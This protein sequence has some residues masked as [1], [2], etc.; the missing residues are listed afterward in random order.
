MNIY[1]L[2]DGERLVTDGTLKEIAGYTGLKPGTVK[3]YGTPSGRNKGNMILIKI[4]EDD[5][6]FIGSN[7]PRAQRSFAGKA[8]IPSNDSYEPVERKTY[9]IK[10]AGPV[11]YLPEPYTKMLY[12]NMFKNWR[13]K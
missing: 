6:V 1:A 2:Y 13:S 10:T 11:E 7:Q 12:K 8:P 9:T 5:D 4:E 3:W